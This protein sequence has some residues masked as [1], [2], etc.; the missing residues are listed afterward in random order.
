MPFKTHPRA[1]KTRRKVVRKIRR[2]AVG[3]LTKQ[4]RAVAVN[5]L[6]PSRRMMGARIRGAKRKLMKLV[7]IPTHTSEEE[8]RKAAAVREQVA[9]LAGV[10]G[11]AK[12]QR[13]R[14]ARGQSGRVRLDAA[15]ARVR[16]ASVHAQLQ[17]AQAQLQSVAPTLE[18]PVNQVVNVRAAGLLKK[19]AVLKHR[20]ALLQHGMDIERPR[21]IHPST[22]RVQR[23]PLKLPP[24]AIPP[25]RAEVLLIA[26]LVARLTPRRSGETQFHYWAKV[27]ALTSRVLVRLTRKGMVVTRDRGEAMRASIEETINEDMEPIQSEIEAGG[28]AADPAADLMEPY[29]DDVAAD[30]EAATTDVTTPVPTGDPTPAQV[31]Q[32]LAYA[33][34]EEALA[35]SAPKEVV[36][37]MAEDSI[38]ADAEP[39]EDTETGMAQ[40]LT[41]RNLVIGG[42]LIGGI[43]L[44]T[45]SR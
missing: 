29:L 1:R 45:Q 10:V 41:P 26:R 37:E 18:L 32:L 27:R 31:E 25:Q 44:L 20:L 3:K 42:A 22:A 8:I 38:F 21:K 36:D 33:G 14:R 30:I 39:E 2:K 15:Q 6:P 34:Q 17:D 43:F 12:A 40:Y 23:K 5:M 7:T 35:T 13:Q 16:I 4:E 24:A 19:R 9:V 28:I 11:A